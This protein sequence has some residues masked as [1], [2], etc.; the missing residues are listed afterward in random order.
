MSGKSSSSRKAISFSSARRPT[1]ARSA[2]GAG[3]EHRVLTPPTVPLTV[4]SRDEID[5]IEYKLG[6]QKVAVGLVTVNFG[7]GVNMRYI[8][9][10]MLCNDYY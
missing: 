5:L 3:D 10:H 1:L 6:L 7:D 9:I 2:A 4:L 8:A